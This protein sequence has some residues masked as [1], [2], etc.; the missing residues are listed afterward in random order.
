[1]A[2]SAVIDMA[3]RRQASAVLR[4][5]ME[6]RLSNAGLDAQYPGASVDRAVH[7][8]YL[9]TWRFQDDFHEYRAEGN[10]ALTSEELA[11]L[12]RCVLF[13][14]TDLIYEWPSLAER[15]L[16]WFAPVPLLGRYARSVPEK[17]EPSVWPF[18]REQDWKRA[19]ESTVTNG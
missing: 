4:G 12:H 5:F 13:L 14:E 7:E 9:R 10:A 19:V 18:Y 2:K 1:M 3:A 6:G 16:R 8:I 11:L 15:A 17:G